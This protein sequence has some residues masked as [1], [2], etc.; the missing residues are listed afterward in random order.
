[1]PSVALATC[2]EFPQL[3]DEDRLVIPELGA[4]GID[5][6]AAVW[7]DADVDWSAFDAVVLRETWDYS[8]RRPEFLDW[9][10]RV[11]AVTLLLNP[12][13]VV[14]W[15]TDKRYLRDLAARMGQRAAQP[16]PGLDRGILP[17]L[18]VN[19]LV[20]AVMMTTLVVGPFYLALGLG[21][22]A[23]LVGL[24]MAVGPVLSIASGVPSFVRAIPRLSNPCTCSD[25]GSNPALLPRTCICSSRDADRA[26]S[27]V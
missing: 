3:D 5:A 13:S 4:L 18:I 19:L 10:R 7:D 16:G 11:S 24:V 15:N 1:M 21:L 23:T 8:D 17:N 9:L 12:A 26:Q 27:S 20:A 25:A 14:E 2:Q 22:P 6:V